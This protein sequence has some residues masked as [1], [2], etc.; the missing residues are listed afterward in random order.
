[1]HYTPNGSPQ[2][3]LSCVGLK[4]T[5]KDKVK[6]L[7]RGDLAVNASFAISAGDAN[8]LVTARKR[9]RNDVVLLN[10]TPHMHL[11]GKSFRFE[12]EYPDGKREILLDV[13]RYDFNW[14]LTYDLVEPLLL[15]KDTVI[16][17]TAYFDNSK[18]NPANPD[19]SKVVR[20][21]DQS[22][23][24]MMIGFFDVVPADKE[25]V[26]DFWEGRKSAVTAKIIDPSGVWRWEHKEG[27]KTIKNVL[28]VKLDD[29]L[30]TGTYKGNGKEHPIKRAA[31]TSNSF[32]FE[33]PVDYQGQKITIAFVGKISGDEIKG[34][35]SFVS[36]AGSLDFPWQAKRD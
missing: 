17:C 19:P 18:N 20:W 34:T 12:A 33:F 4:F 8:H 14:Q 3:D 31:I 1:M 11:R 30:V 2:E 16:H 22:F 27:L 23:E 36:D 5:T 7:V 28:M 26:N 29:K 24:E 15:P 10:L 21:G 9:I 32:S 6:K 25:E 13:P 35:V